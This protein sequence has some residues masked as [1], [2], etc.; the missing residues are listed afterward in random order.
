M[1]EPIKLITTRSDADVATDIKNALADRLARVC[2]LM[3]AAQDTGLTVNF[4]IG[5]D[6]RNRN[7][8]VGLSVVKVL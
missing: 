8:I 5:K 4:S 2:E 3:D 7:V 6:W 1:P